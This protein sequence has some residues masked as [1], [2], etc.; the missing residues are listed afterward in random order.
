[1]DCGC[2]VA[3][4]QYFR[5]LKN[6]LAGDASLDSREKLISGSDRWSMAFEGGLR[7]L[8][9]FNAVDIDVKAESRWRP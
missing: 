9:L 4:L 5:D 8:G 1:M 3:K 7:N 2:V 6:P